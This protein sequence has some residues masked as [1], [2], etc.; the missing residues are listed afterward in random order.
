[1][2]KF[3]K[4]I[5]RSKTTQIVL[6]CIG[7]FYLWFVF[8]T[9]RWKYVGLHHIEHLIHS[10]TPFIAAFWHGRLAMLPFLW[11]WNTPFYMLLSEHGDGRFISKIIQHRKIKSIYGSSTRGGAQAALL[12]VRE[13]KRGHCMGIT[14]DGPKGPRHKASDGLIHIAR[15]SDAPV[16]PVSYSLKRHKFLKTW[17]RFLVPLPFT[18]GIFVIGEPITVSQDKSPD[19]LNHTKEQLTQSLLTVETKADHFLSG[20]VTES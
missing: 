11:R 3:I 20:T 6:A 13:L 14:P 16:I 19:A 1:M 8:K 18:H 10:N 5:L 15:L 7:Y 2:K 12:C 17:D 9:T 4:K